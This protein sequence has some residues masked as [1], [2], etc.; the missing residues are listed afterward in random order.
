MNEKFKVTEILVYPALY[1]RS[2]EAA[3]VKTGLQKCNCKPTSNQQ[4][5]KLAFEKATVT[6]VL[7]SSRP[8]CAVCTIH[9][10][11]AP[12]ALTWKG[13]PTNIFIQNRRRKMLSPDIWA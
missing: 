6:L 4:Q 9:S 11:K 5:L 10:L 13:K 1:I 12:H 8:G 7:A 3:G 2:S